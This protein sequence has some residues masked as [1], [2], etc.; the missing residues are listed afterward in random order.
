MKILTALPLV[1]ALAAMLGTATPAHAEYDELDP[2]KAAT[3]DKRMFGGPV[4]DKASACFV[5]R[6]DARHLAQHPQQKVSVL[7]LLVTAE[8]TPDEPTSYAFRAGVELR[9]R[10]GSFDGGNSCDRLMSETRG[11]EISFSCAQGCETLGLEIALSKDNKSSIVRL[12][13]IE[14]WPHGKA[15][16]DTE[17]LQGGA[18]DKVFRLDRVDSQECAD[19]IPDPREV[20]ALQPK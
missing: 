14:I 20:A 19:L 2:A 17:T 11:R 12:D 8:K 5:R 7:K 4:G 15:D 1:A 13:S 18:D 3:F 9:N 16:G 6:Y 10:P